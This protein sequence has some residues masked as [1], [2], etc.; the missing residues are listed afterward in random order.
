VRITKILA[1]LSLAVALT[2]GGLVGATAPASAATVTSGTTTLSVQLSF[3]VQAT[4]AGIIA[5]PQKPATTQFNSTTNNVDVAFPAT[6]GDANAKNLAGFLQHSGSILLVNCH[7]GHR[8]TLTALVFDVADTV[9]TA[10][11]SG[12]TTPVTVFELIPPVSATQSGTTN[13]FTAAGLAIEPDG[14]AYLDSALGTTF[15]TADQ[16]IGSFSSTWTLA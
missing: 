6:G 11:P 13:T 10:V 2:A 1:G 14:A 4:N 16:L 12:S 9:V 15:F 3:L 5:I 8:V 7:N